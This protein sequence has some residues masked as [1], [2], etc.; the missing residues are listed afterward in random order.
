MRQV[1]INPTCSSDIT[2]S[3]LRHVE[4]D[5]RACTSVESAVTADELLTPRAGTLSTNE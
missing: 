1:L 4:F 2:L 5:V 3:R